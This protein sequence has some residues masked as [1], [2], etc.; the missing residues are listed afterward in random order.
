M[1]PA[2]DIGIVGAGQLA[3]MTVQAA[4]SLGLRVRVLARRADDG[5][6]L[7]WPE[8]LIGNPTSRDAV[9]EMARSCRVLTFDHE[10]V[11]AAHLAELEAEGRVL[12][13]SART[14]AI[15][16][17]KWLQRTLLAERGLP[18][19][20][21]ARVE[22]ARDLLA[23]GAAHGWPVV[24]KAVRGGYDGRGV[25]MLDEPAVA[26]PFVVRAL[27]AGT[28]LLVEERVAI[29]KELAVLVARRA[30]GET[31]VYPVVETVQVAGICHEVLAPA[32]IPAATATEARRIALAAAEVIG[33]TGLL[34]VELFLAD[35]CLTV[36]ELAARPH[37]SAHYTIE[38]CVTSQFEN[39]LR[40]ALDLPLGSTALVAPAAV[41]VNVLGNG[42]AADPHTHLAAALAV[43][44]AHVHLYQKEPRPGR[45]IGHVTV[46]G[47]D[48][49]E[50]RARAWLARERLTGWP[51]ETAE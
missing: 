51:K 13:P 46:T 21:F 45:K 18:T 1:S 14:V 39:L 5:A 20:A 4:I 25:W 29:D 44:G 15:G 37:N 24:A 35:G 11:D 16:Q 2:Y 32:R 50:V 33:L 31:A 10:L 12:A 36:N 19:P 17:D 47:D 49:D 3:R 7:V 28:P 26:E 8:V 27:A 34:A 38:G 23:F 22:S 41:M 43:E 6:A 9:A 30:D 40:A 42:D 48:M